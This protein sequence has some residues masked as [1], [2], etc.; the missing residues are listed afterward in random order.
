MSEID[1]DEDD[2]NRLLNDDY[3]KKEDQKTTVTRSTNEKSS[4]YNNEIN[5]LPYNKAF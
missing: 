2:F 5:T 4:L 3:K 1:Y